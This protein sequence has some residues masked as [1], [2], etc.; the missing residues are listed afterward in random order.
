M[1]RELT[2][3]E[4]ERLV[5]AFGI[6][7]E[8]ARNAGI[9]AVELHAHAGHL[10]DQF[11]T[12]LW[13]KRKD[14]YGGNLEG[15][16]RFAMEIIG[17]IKKAAGNDFPVIYRFGL[18]HY[19]EGGR[20]VEE[21]LEITR[22]L[23][24]AGIDAFHIDAGCHEVRYWGTPPTTQ[25]PGCSV[26]LAQEVK[27]VVKVPV[28]S[29]GKL[30]YAELAE[31]VLQEEKAD[32]IALGRA[33]LADPEWPNKVREKRLEDIRPC[34][35]CYE[36]CLERVNEKK[37]ISCA[38]NPTT[39][40]EREFALKPAEKRK[41]VLVV[42]GGPAGME[43]ARIAALRGH[44]VALWEKSGTL[45]G[46]LTPASVPSF[47]QD[48]K[49]FIKYLS[50]QMKD[51][52]IAIEFGKEATLE[53][54]QQMKPEVLFMATGATPIIPQIPGVER[55]N[56]VTAVQILLGDKKVGNSGVLIR[57][58]LVGCE[59]A[60][61]LAQQGKKITIVEI[62]AKIA[63]D[64]FISNKMHLLK[65]LK[66]AETKILTETQVLE[67]AENGVWV[68]NKPGNRS[69]IQADTVVLATGLEAE[70][71]GW[72]TL[73]KDIP[74]VYFLGDCVQPRKILSAIWEGFRK[75]RLI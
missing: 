35:G 46:S 73:K 63:N 45:G 61:Y 57:G 53:L 67:I 71:G 1:T 36:G 14:K 28:I 3:E 52:G 27:K 59:T 68:V 6:A 40:M 69:L 7:A 56:V 4:I 51:L 62:L 13:N 41:S 8:I 74:E 32:F 39:G 54:I 60:L 15:R 33:L 65:L 5:Q 48:Y 70:K 49:S 29:V 19:Y 11:Q 26:H 30:G 18:T 47:K 16:L 75:A 9:D 12:A 42:G 34:I 22:R 38:V 66:D 24:A 72:E 37:Y 64:M 10:L 58:G 55:S 2:I 44:R 17:A 23:E 20:D 25:V 31:E 21:G 50:H 43:A